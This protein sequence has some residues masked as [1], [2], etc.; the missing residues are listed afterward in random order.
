VARRR[1]KSVEELSD[2]PDLRRWQVEQLGEDFVRALRDAP[3]SSRK[4]TSAGERAST[5][6]PTGGT[7]R[8]DSPYKQ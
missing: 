3:S 8:D 6:R 4:A 1:P 5:G 7:K 2:I